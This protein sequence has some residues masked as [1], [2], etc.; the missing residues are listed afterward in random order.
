[1]CINI[2]HVDPDADAGPDADA[3]GTAIVLLY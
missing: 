2:L 3:E 1:M